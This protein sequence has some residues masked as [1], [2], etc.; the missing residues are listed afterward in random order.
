MSFRKRQ[1]LIRRIALGFAVAAVATP[2]VAQ[3]HVEG[4]GS[5]SVPL[6]RDIVSSYPDQRAVQATGNQGAS[7]VSPVSYPD[8]RKVHAPGNVS[9]PTGSLVNYRDQRGIQVVPSGQ[10]AP[11]ATR[12]NNPVAEPV[13]APASGGTGFDWGDAGIGA[14]FALGLAG[15]GV[16]A[17]RSARRVTLAGS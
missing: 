13:T 1:R 11:I 3:A 8:Q 16:V 9:A 2:T 4:G 17:L 15:L 10:A 14:G 5:G 6:S 12:T 7:I